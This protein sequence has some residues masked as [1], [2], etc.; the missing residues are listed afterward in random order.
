MDDEQKF[1]KKRPIRTI[2][3]LV[4]IAIAIGTIFLYLSAF[5]APGETLEPES[6]VVALNTDQS[7]VV[8]K[9]KSAGFIKNAWAFSFAFRWGGGS[10]IAPGGYPISKA[11][12]VWQVALVLTREPS[13]KWVVIPEGLRKEETADILARELGWIDEE[14]EKWIT[15]YTALEYDYIEGVYFPDTYLI[16]TDEP[17]LEVAKRLRARFEEK[18]APYAKGALEQNIR[19]PT[20]LKLAS[21][22]QREAA[23]R[24]DMPQIAGILWNRLLADM[25]LEVD[26]TLQY[27]RGDTGSGWWAPITPADKQLDSPYNTYRHEGLPP[28]PIANPGVGA[29]DAVLY[30]EETACLYYLHDNSGMI[31]CAET[32]EEHL[33]N[34]EKYLR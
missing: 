20:L 23:G 19:W 30:P 26:A 6:F 28:H 7:T 4:G 31:H 13:L 32:Y 11:M 2:A 5:G 8:E 29:I 1:Q 12:N 27:A 21:I 3:T 16:P 17:P 15:T 24:E 25:R 9:L 18:F 33:E 34:I 22:V 14:K 10:E